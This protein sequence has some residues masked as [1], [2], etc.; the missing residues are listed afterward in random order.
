MHSVASKAESFVE[1]AIHLAA[2]ATAYKFPV[3][4]TIT[5]RQAT[6]ADQTV[7]TS[8]QIVDLDMIV[9]SGNANMQVGAAETTA[10]TS[11]QIADLGT[12]ATS[13]SVNTQ[14]VDIAAYQADH[15]VGLLIA[16]VAQTNA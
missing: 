8:I 9:D 10:V 2:V 5:V 15:S 3:I 12:I 6:A 1:T 14:A 4:T 11:T 16:R 13:D 7:V